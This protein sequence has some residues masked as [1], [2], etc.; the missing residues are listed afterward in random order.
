MKKKLFAIVMSATMVMS[1]MPSIAFA[2]TTPAPADD[3]TACT[4]AKYGS[5][6]YALVPTGA[7]IARDNVE[8]VSAAKAEPTCDKDVVQ[9]HFCEKCGHVEQ[10]GTSRLE[11]SHT[12]G[13]PQTIKYD[14]GGY[15]T[16]K[17][18]TACGDEVVDDK[19]DAGT[20][21]TYEIKVVKE[22]ACDVNEETAKVCTICGYQNGAAT[23][24]KGSALSHKYTDRKNVAAAGVTPQ[25]DYTNATEY[26]APTCQYSGYA[27]YKCELCGKVMKRY[28][29]V[30]GLE[31]KAHAWSETKIVSEA[32]CTKYAQRGQICT[33][34]VEG[35]SPKNP[36]QF[37]V[38]QTQN[39][40]D[41]GPAPSHKYAADP[42]KADKA[43]T[44]TEDGY[45]YVKCTVCGDTTPSGKVDKL[46]HSYTGER[47]EVR[48]ADC[49]NS[50]LFGYK[51]SRCD[52]YDEATTTVGA[53]ALGHSYEI[54]VKLT[55]CTDTPQ[56]AKLCSV[57]G[58]PGD[59]GFAFRNMSTEEKKEYAAELENLKVDAH[60]FSLNDVV[61]ATCAKEGYKLYKCP[62][63]ETRKETIAKLPHTSVV[64][65]VDATCTEAGVKTTKCSVCDEVIDTVELPAL[66]HD[67]VK[68][69]DVVEPTCTEA[70]HQGYKCSACDE[71]KVEELAALG[72]KEEVLPAVKAT[73]TKTGLTEGKKCSVCGE[74]LEAQTVTV[75]KANTPSVK[76]GKKSLTATAAKVTGATKYQ[77]AY[78]R[79]GS[80]YTWKYA[81]A[82]TKSAQTIKNLVKGKKYYVKVRTISGDV[83]GAWS[84][85]KAVTVK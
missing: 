77:V 85:T 9:V 3:V 40:K 44:C 20:K 15:R 46:G 84:S 65:T 52:A 48:P 5:T 49:E 2:G 53:A 4:H 51:C 57:C 39:L 76:A 68:T 41:F 36:E 74:V 60:A 82:S 66:G 35:V 16:I 6:E 12:Y 19:R 58:K 62:C 71:T 83:V 38:V 55:K 33:T 13:D 63:G 31:K 56:I 45:K 1:F 70:G 67:F 42:D 78:K 28:D 79:S 11:K 32:T 22:A 30:D 25:Y 73:A 43:A 37:L 21:H 14:C 75:A 69:D 29:G 80:K 23:E 47:V 81:K 7:T 10:V 26:L 18:C 24:T 59:K 64:E 61:D 50:Q 17:K 27:I 72:H 54:K 8:V 34:C